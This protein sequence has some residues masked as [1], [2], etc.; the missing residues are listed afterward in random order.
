[1]RGKNIHALQQ[2]FIIFKRL[3]RIDRKQAKNSELPGKRTSHHLISIMNKLKKANI[4]EIKSESE[5]EE[6]IGE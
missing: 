3:Q 5:S 4:K 2:E 1:M 6:E